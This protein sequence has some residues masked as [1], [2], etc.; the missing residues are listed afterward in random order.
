MAITQREVKNKKDSK[1]MLTGKEGFVYDVNIKYTTP[2][3]HKKTYA[4]RGFLTKKEASLHEA[5]MKL[6]LN[7]S[8]Q[9]STVIMGKKTVQEYMEKWLNEYVKEN[10]RPSTYSNYRNI[11][12]NYIYPYIGNIQINKLNHY[13]KMKLH[14]F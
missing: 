10:L 11:S 12:R 14:L 13:M 7:S 8:S 4:K 6:K 5:E 2:D 3:G 9:I 1:G